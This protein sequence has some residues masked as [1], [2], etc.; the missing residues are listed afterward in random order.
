MSKLHGTRRCQVDQVMVSPRASC[1]SGEVAQSGAP[2]DET[3]ELATS[4]YTYLEHSDGNESHH[5]SHCWPSQ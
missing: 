3:T 2:R 4:Y 5:K 1:G